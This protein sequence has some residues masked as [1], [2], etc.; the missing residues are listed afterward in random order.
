MTEAAGKNKTVKQFMIAE[1]GK[2]NH[3]LFSGI[4]Q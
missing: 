3:F 4:D 2:R 1:T